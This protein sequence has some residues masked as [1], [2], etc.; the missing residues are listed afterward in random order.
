MYRE[1]VFVHSDRNR[2]LCVS[3]KFSIGA[4]QCINGLAWI[5][6]LLCWFDDRFMFSHH[7]GNHLCLFCLVGGM[8]GRKRRR[9]ARLQFHHLRHG[10]QRL[11]DNRQF[12]D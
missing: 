9:P 7:H 10:G 6:V 8:Y 5:H 4:V 2:H 12:N 1:F 11:H 3:L